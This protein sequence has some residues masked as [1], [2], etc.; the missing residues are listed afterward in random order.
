MGALLTI[1]DIERIY[2]WPLLE[3]F[4]SELQYMMIVS[5]QYYTLSIVLFDIGDFYFIQLLIFIVQLPLLLSPIIYSTW[6]S[7][8]DSWLD[9]LGSFII[10]EE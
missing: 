7:H 2:G 8:P 1:T 10:N 4:Y 5:I 6:S 3:D 9:Q